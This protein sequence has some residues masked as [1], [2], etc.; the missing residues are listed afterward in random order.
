PD[1]LDTETRALLAL[2]LIP[3]IGPRLSQALIER[4]GSAK[5]AIAAPH[6]ELRMVPRLGLGR[7]QQ[8]ASINHAANVAKELAL[9]G[10]HGVSLL[11]PQS[12]EYPHV[13]AEIKSPPGFLYVRASLNAVDANAMAIVGARA[14]TDYGKRMTDRLATGL[15]RA[16][17]TV[18]SG[19]AY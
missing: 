9:L 4:F 15:A 11:T 17:Y 8:I 7:A 14:C 3:G 5:A 10:E 16:G 13:L 19:L 2:H 18:V 6:D 12:P 1:S